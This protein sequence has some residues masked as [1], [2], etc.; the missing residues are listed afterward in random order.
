V[1]KLLRYIRAT[2][3]ANE[4]ADVPDREYLDRFARNRDE[5]AF[6]ALVGRYCGSVWAVCRRLLDREQD[7]EDTFQAT[8]LT[9]ARKAGSIRAGASLPAWLHQVARRVAANLRRD[10]R[11]RADTEAEAA[12]IRGGRSAD[13]TWREGVAV[14]DEELARLPERYRAVLIVCCLDGRSRDEAAS[15]LGWSEGQ[16]KGRL[17]RARELLRRRLERRG[18]GLAALLLAAGLAPPSLV[19]STV[20]AAVSFVAG[21]AT[22][23]VVSSKVAL[24][25]EGAVN[26]L[27]SPTF[28]LMAASLVAVALAG[29]GLL[30][31][32]M[33]RPAADGGGAQMNDADEEAKAQHEAEVAAR[34]AAAKAAKAK[35]T[36]TFPT[37]AKRGEIKV[38]FE[39]VTI[40]VRP[41]FRATRMP[42]SVRVCGDGVCEYRIEERPARGNEPKWDP[43]YLKHT[44]TLEKLHR[45]EGL[46]KKADWL[47]AAPQATPQLHATRFGLTLKRNGETRTLTVEGEPSEPYKSLTAFFLGVAHQEN[48]LYRLERLPAKERVEACRQIDSYARAEMGERYSKPPYE[49]DLRRYAPTFQRYVRDPFT[50]SKEE[51]VPALRLFG[52]FKSEREREHIAAL[53]NDREQNVRAAVAQALGALGGKESVPVLRRMVRGSSEAAWQLVRLGPVA[54]PTVVE[55]IEA[56]TD[57]TDE[58]EPGFLDYERLIRAYIDHWEQLPGPVDPRVLAAVR[59]SMAAPKVKAYRTEYH[60][61]LLDLASRPSPPK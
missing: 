38:D 18:F 7:A 40:T 29:G 1:N 25:A 41:S 37:P 23:G 12:S 45:L 58:R 57:P 11:R 28:K 55:V 13:L 48:L 22:P 6:A 51:L 56:G 43:A 47:T 33:A 46:L 15:H 42:E 32:H 4:A 9:L 34:E 59:K 24:L 8:F 5:A 21:S 27:V 31:Y 49:I 61:K 14:L 3:P 20:A 53:S 26:D 60:K 30:A 19:A 17:E 16:V 39:E 52:H 2:A 44:L 50:H 10:A 35:E 54:V 36:P